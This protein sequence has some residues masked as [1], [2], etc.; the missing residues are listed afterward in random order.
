[1]TKN[2]SR[3][4][5]IKGSVAAG[6]AGA[7]STVLPKS[8]MAKTGK[9]IKWR[10]QT[11]WP[12]GVGYYE[13]VYVEFCN[14]VREATNGELDITPMPPN[15]VVPTKNVFQALG[16]NRLDAALIWPTY[17]LGQVPVAVHI[18]GNLFMWERA[19]EMFTYFYDW[20]A[21]EIFR[22][23]YGKFNVHFL[24]PTCETGVTLWCKKPIRNIDDFKGLKVRSTGAAA[25][26]FKKAGATPV[27]FPGAELYQALQTG[28]CD[29]VHWGPVSGG[30]SMK[31]QEV[32][33]YIV[34]PNL[35]GID[36]GE[37]IISKK[38]WD[39]LPK[40]MQIIVEECAKGAA[41]NHLRWTGYNDDLCLD[42][43]KKNNMG[44]ISYMEK[45][46]I[47]QMRKYSFDVV[48]EYSKRDPKYCKKA[49]DLLK[50]QMKMKGRI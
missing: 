36:N 44:E 29:G 20:G 42:E 11:H 26:V 3:R 1:M 39:N 25:D 32:T 2:I 45:D 8:V 17:W 48:E 47:D 10:M 40:D 12:T 5:I 19:H 7:A 24:S 37:I 33:K 31:F 22:E 34:Q 35:T 28:V 27:F 14:R 38:K 49:G 41:I 16:Q 18:N 30:W 13:D 9:K 21:I 50:A 6:I 15:A 23:A 46:T 43:F 4:Q